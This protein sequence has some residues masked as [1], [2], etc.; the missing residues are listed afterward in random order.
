MAR[1]P[2]ASVAVAASTLAEVFFEDAV[3]QVSDR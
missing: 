1:A 2:S 3:R